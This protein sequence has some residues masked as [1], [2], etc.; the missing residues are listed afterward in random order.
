[1]KFCNRIYDSICDCLRGKSFRMGIFMMHRIGIISDT[2]GLLRPEVV[3]T[4]KD[5]EAILHGGDINS[6]KILDELNQIAP[7]YAV[8][9]NNDKEWAKDL[10]ETLSIEL[11]GIHFFMVHNKKYIPKNL[12]SINVVVCGHSHKYEEKQINGM[13]LL[14]PGSCGPRR[15]TQPITF[16]VLEIW[17][18]HTFRVEKVEISHVQ[19][20][21]LTANVGRNSLEEQMEG[22]DTKR[23]VK[24]VMRDTDKGIP[25]SDIA[26]KNDISVELA[27]LICRLYLTHPGVS[28]DGIMGKMGL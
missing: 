27:E 5:C 13:L 22:R 23:I 15:F 28:E 3:E 9:G 6:A 10:Q 20:D 12:E 25:V 21:G 17:E 24:S 8:R 16:A 14:N 11:H 2:H 19:K 18:D 26:V 7:T 4:L 1:M